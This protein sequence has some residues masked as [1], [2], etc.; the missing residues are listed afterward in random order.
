MNLRSN[1]LAALFITLSF[2]GANVKVLGSIAFDSMPG[3]LGTLILGTAYGAAIG[4]AGHFLTALLSG[5]PLTIPVHLV[6]M[7]IMAVTMAVFGIIYRRLADANRFS[8]KG[9]LVA[10]GVAVLLNG[11]LGLLVLSPLLVPVLGQA[12][13]LAL[14]PILSGVAALNILLAFIIYRLLGKAAAKA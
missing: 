1:I 10:G 7:G 6:I 12:G 8:V 14:L 11:P 3:F 9:A 13:I 4:A 2:I 5:F